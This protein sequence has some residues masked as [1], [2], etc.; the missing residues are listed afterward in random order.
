MALLV[1]IILAIVAVV[2]VV[3]FLQ[4][5]Y[6]KST[7]DTALL[8]TG[9]GGR[10]VAL[11]GGFF[12]LPILH[13]V[14]EINMRAHR[15]MVQR[16]G[17]MGLLTEDRLRMDASLEF[18]VRVLADAQ[19]VA[20]AAQAF[21]ARALRSEELGQMLEARFIDIVQSCAATRTLDALH[22]RRG[23]FVQAIREAL[24]GELKANGL[25]L[26][27]VALIRLDQTPFSSLNENNV[28]N[29]VGMR[30]LAEI[31]ATNKKQRAQ[32]EA[33]AEV[34][35]AQTQ[36]SAHKRRKELQQEQQ[37]TDMNVHMAVEN[38][39]VRTEAEIGRAR[40]GAQ[41]EIEQARLQRERDVSAAEIEREQALAR[42]RLQSQLSLEL[43]RVEQAIA[44]S[45]QQQQEALA[46]IEGE[47]ARTKL[48][49]EQEA[50]MTQREQLIAERN[51]LLALARVEQE[52]QADAVKAR[53]DAERQLAL[54]RAQVE[55]T[56][57]QALAEQARMEAEAQGQAARIAAENT[58]SE[59]LM[60]LRLELARIEAIPVLAE[61]VAQP[62]QKI[63]SIRVHHLSGLGGNGN[64]LGNAGQA[65]L[66]AA[67]GPLDA[68]YDMALN[69]PILKKL[70]ETLGA[71]LDMTVPQLARAESDHVR[72]IADHKKA[73]PPTTSTQPTHPP[74]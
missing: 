62:L 11:D 46:A 15:V 44:L 73:I 70:G 51:R 66:S 14:D 49:L 65:G 35:V 54:A 18:R 1:W 41:R 60:R 17:D 37:Q 24:D 5:F 31:V 29:A 7:R 42:A 4:R 33:D 40:E 72:A 45:Q 43:Q 9:A 28:F 57:A 59:A 56:R 2:V 47:Q 71:D 36:L 20:A 25:V 13:R 74:A 26:E 50:G 8:R 53:S 30:K 23:E 69:L 34:A 63:D 32:T 67:S 16:A 21:G 64:A 19:G 39:R 61:K 52:A 22:E 55:V 48:L 27:A 68:I 6:R 58:Q 3:A 38:A 12:A 10:K